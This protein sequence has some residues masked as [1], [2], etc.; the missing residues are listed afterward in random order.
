MLVN[1]VFENTLLDA[2]IRER[3]TAETVLNSI[4]PLSFVATAI[5]PEHFTVAVTLVIFVAA[6]I[7]IA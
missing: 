7:L 5:C 3:H 6:L 4:L 2:P 1:V